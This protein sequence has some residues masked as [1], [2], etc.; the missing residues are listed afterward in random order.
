MQRWVVRT[1]WVHI[2]AAPSVLSV[3]FLVWQVE[4]KKND[5]EG[6]RRRT[7]DWGN[8]GVF[9]DHASGALCTERFVPVMTRSS[10]VFC[11]FSFS[12][13]TI[14]PSGS[15]GSCLGHTLAQGES[16]LIMCSLMEH[17]YLNQE[18]SYLDHESLREQL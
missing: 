4:L 13:H 15:S 2:L 3:P 10:D 16:K 1:F 7:K 5:D 9:M 8:G 18:E 12:C 17:P 11:T 6:G 14:L